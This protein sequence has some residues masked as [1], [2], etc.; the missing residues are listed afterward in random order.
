M[1]IL[2]DIKSGIEYTNIVYPLI[3]PFAYA[4]IVW[5]N[6]EQTLIYKVDQP[7]LDEEEQSY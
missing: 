3:P 1:I 7:D 2:P 4:R 6:E 5:N